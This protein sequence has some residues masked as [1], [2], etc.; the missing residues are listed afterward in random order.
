MRFG[1]AR[2]STLDQNLD[3]QIEALLAQGIEGK[4]IFTDK[5]SGAKER[6]EGLDDLLSRLREGDS[7]TVLSFDRLARSTKQLLSIS[8]KLESLGVDL[9]SLKESID[10]SS[11]QGKLFFTITSAF[12]EFERAMIKERQAEGIAIAKA[13]RGQ[14]GGRPKVAQEKLEAAIA[15]YQGGKMSSAKIAETTGVSR[16][17]LYRELEKRGIRRS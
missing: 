15:L 3:R 6:R 10:T 14:C 12:A 7:V 4:N 2:V 16:A 8:E 5:V 13:K 17:T 1:Y 9:V 11:P